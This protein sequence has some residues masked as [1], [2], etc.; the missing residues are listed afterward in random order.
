MRL[1]DQMK[2]ILQ[3]KNISWLNYMQLERW[4]NEWVKNYNKGRE[5]TKY[6]QFLLSYEDI[7]MTDSVKGTVSKIY[8][9]LLNVEEEEYGKEGLKSVWEQ[10]LGKRINGEKWMNVEN[11]GVT[12]YVSENKRIF[13]PNWT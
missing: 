2:Q 10:D 4:T 3:N 8:G 13:F 5:Y 9:F 6:E 11:E 7:Q 12:I 1:K